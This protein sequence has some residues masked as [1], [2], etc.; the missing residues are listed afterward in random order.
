[1]MDFVRR[2]AERRREEMDVYLVVNG[3]TFYGNSARLVSIDMFAVMMLRSE[4]AETVDGSEKSDA[5]V[6]I[7]D[8]GRVNEA[9][10]LRAK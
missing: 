5:I 8:K 10:S 4:R 6:R 9:D 7:L 3:E 1:M 2:A